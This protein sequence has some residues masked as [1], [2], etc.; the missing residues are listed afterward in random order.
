LV[1]GGDRRPSGGSGRYS[2]DAVIVAVNAPR[3][4]AE[5]FG[6]ASAGWP[7]AQIDVTYLAG[8]ETRQAK[9]A[10]QETASAAAGAPPRNAPLPTAP[11]PLDDRATP[12]ATDHAASSA[13]DRAEIDSLKHRVQ[14]LEQRIDQ[15][16]RAAKK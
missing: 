12:P 10:L 8:G 9:V 16:E 14:E 1:V 3:R 7:S 15:L 2:V 4:I 11:T 13:A 6:A 5:R